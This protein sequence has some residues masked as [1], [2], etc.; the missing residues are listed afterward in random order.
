MAVVLLAGAGHLG[1][2]WLIWTGVGVGLVGLGALLGLAY[3]GWEARRAAD[4][5]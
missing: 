1:V 3:L 4:A 2:G 5:D